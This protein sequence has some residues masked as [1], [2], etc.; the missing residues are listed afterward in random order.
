MA[1]RRTFMAAWKG[2]KEL[3]VFDKVKEDDVTTSL[4][5]KEINGEELPSYLPGQFISVRVKNGEELSP[6]RAYSLSSNYRK[7]YYRISIKIE[8]KGLVSPMLCEQVQVGDTLM[9]TAPVGKFYLKESDKPAIFFGGGIGVTPMLAMAQ[10]LEHSERP[11][12]FIYCAKNQKFVSF[13]EEIKE[14]AKIGDRVKTTLIF[15]DPLDT[16]VEGVD[17]DMRG[18]ITEEWIAKNLPLDGEFYFCGPVPFMKSLYHKLTDLGVSPEFINYEL[19]AGGVDI[20][21]RDEE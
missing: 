15:S 13:K 1:A 3:L 14:L 7:D 12:H 21:V 6:A 8:E 18:R 9:C 10:E 17:Y 19:F 2:F 20:T 16:E 5:L 4:Y 11:V